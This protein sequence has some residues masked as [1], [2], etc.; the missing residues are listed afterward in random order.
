MGVARPPKG[1]GSGHF[2]SD[3]FAACRARLSLPKPGAAV[4]PAVAVSEPMLHRSDNLS[5]PTAQIATIV[6][7][8]LLLACAISMAAVAALA[9]G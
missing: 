5:A 8:E 7:F 1:R 3:T 6:G 9:A 4:P 2:E